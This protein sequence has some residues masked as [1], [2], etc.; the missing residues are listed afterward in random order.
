MEYD[1]KTIDGVRPPNDELGMGVLPSRSAK[2]LVRKRR[3]G[4][5]W[6][7]VGERF[8]APLSWT[9]FTFVCPFVLYLW[10]GFTYQTKE[11]ELFSILHTAFPDGKVPLTNVPKRLA[12]PTHSASTLSH[13]I[14]WNKEYISTV[15][16]RKAISVCFAPPPPVRKNQ[17][18]PMPRNLPIIRC[19]KGD[20]PCPAHSYHSY[21]PPLEDRFDHWYRELIGYPKR[22]SPPKPNASYYPLFNKAFVEKNMQ[23]VSEKEYADGGLSC[24]PDNH[25]RTAPPEGCRFVALLD[26]AFTAALYGFCLPA[27]PTDALIIAVKERF[28]EYGYFHFPNCHI[29]RVSFSVSIVVLLYDWPIDQQSEIEV[30]F[31][32]MGLWYQKQDDTYTTTTLRSASPSWTGPRNYGTPWRLSSI[33]VELV[34]KYSDHYER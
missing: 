22:F 5:N 24:L 3:G 27:L 23:G 9:R 14:L 33:V 25:F 13:S 11:P 29:C 17:H 26:I 19:G 21:C 34:S 20:D 31:T 8:D 18:L 15:L 4:V 16:I 6:R 2:L 12:Q 28:P 10:C 1:L 30:Y 7:C 32:K